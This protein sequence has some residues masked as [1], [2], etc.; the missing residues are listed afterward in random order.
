MSDIDP[1]LNLQPPERRLA[2][3]LQTERPLPTAGFRG[4]LGRRL[5]ALD[6]GHGVR[7]ARLRLLTATYLI[8]GATLIGLGAAQATGLL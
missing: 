3:R 1:D 4:A 5:V 2:E 6:P 7:P 8:G